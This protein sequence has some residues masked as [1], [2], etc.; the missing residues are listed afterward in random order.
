MWSGGPNYSGALTLTQ[1]YPVNSLQVAAARHNGMLLD[2]DMN[3]LGVLQ[4]VPE[5]SSFV[6][7]GLIAA[8]VSGK[9]LN[10]T[11]WLAAMRTRVSAG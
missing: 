1:N 9:L 6:L 8:A 3:G 4:A 2:P 11:G 7:L 10:L 5:P